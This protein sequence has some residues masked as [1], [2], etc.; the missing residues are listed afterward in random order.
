LPQQRAFS[1]ELAVSEPA[2][3]K[4][5]GYPRFAEEEYAARLLEL[6]ELGVDSIILGGRTII[7]G[8]HIAG[9]GCVGIVVKAKA[10]GRLC[11]LKVRR[12][13][14]NR[15]DMRDEVKYH[16][17]ANG[18]GVGPKLL[19][20]TSNFM[21]MEFAE[22]QSIIEWV[23]GGLFKKQ[24]AAIVKTILEQCFALDRA[25]LDHGELAHLDRHI[26]VDGTSATI[27]DFESAST[28]RKM[29]N[30]SSAG[31]SLFV[32]GAIAGTLFKILP[33]GRDD[34]IDA[35]RKYK[36]EQTRENLEA[37]LATAI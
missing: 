22:G 3:Q 19:G 24:A 17:I 26:I 16:L 7:G 5:L 14:A 23:Q 37:V 27:I 4:I 25:G 36:R 2:L 15:P 30:V 35:L 8:T 31:Q 13:D 33:H 18:A 1:A 29:S 9:K 28:T 6:K 10:Q 20:H 11:A 21:L 34:A 12:T 32:S